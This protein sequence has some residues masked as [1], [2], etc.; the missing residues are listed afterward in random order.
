MKKQWILILLLAFAILFF[1][2]KWEAKR[3]FVE[4]PGLKNTVRTILEKKHYRFTFTNERKNSLV[5]EKNR[6]IVPPNNVVLNLDWDAETKK[7][8]KQLIGSFFQDIVFSATETKIATR[9]I[10]LEAAIESFFENKNTLF[11]NSYYC[12]FMYIFSKER[13]VARYDPKTGE[14][15]LFEQ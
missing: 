10:I 6:V 13:C 5:I 9:D 14:F 11:E 2:I 15:V 3:V 12:G 1:R 8:V 4:D 7:K